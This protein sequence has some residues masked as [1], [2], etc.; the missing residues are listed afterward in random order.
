MTESLTGVGMGERE[1]DRERD[2]PVSFDSR[3][4]EMKR[5]IER[6][7]RRQRVRRWLVV[8]NLIVMLS[9][10]LLTYGWDAFVI[11]LS[12]SSL[13]RIA[14]QRCKRRRRSMLR[15]PLSALPWLGVRRLGW[16]A[17]YVT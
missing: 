16:G 2:T 7:E 5:S 14:E 17:G 1:S 13:Q 11:A 8:A 15:P 12:F 3:L 6:A 9:L 4:A 10:V